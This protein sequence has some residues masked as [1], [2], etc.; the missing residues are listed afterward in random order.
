MAE[1]IAEMEEMDSVSR[2]GP[3]LHYEEVWTYKLQDTTLKKL[4]EPDHQAQTGEWTITENCKPPKINFI[5]EQGSRR[6]NAFKTSEGSLIMGGE[7]PWNEAKYSPSARKQGGEKPGPR[8][9]T[10]G[11]TSLPPGTAILHR[12][13]RQSQP[14]KRKST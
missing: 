13:L 12:H 4:M 11:G 2:A 14:E 1:A 9:S 3:N 7:P 6:L 5:G 8:A 10:T